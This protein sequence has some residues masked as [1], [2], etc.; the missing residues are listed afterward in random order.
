V[1]RRETNLGFLAVGRSR[2]AGWSKYNSGKSWFNLKK[3]FRRREEGGKRVPDATSLGGE[4]HRRRFHNPRKP[5]GAE[6]GICADVA[7]WTGGRIKRAVLGQPGKKGIADWALSSS[8]EIG[9]FENC[10]V[11]EWCQAQQSGG[12]KGEKEGK[13]RKKWKR[14]L[15]WLSPKKI[16]A[17]HS[18]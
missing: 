1:G 7:G 11:L 3:Q 9:R 6:N 4:K 2:N 8:P 16:G 17:N 14:G 13:E 18:L 10:E 5:E 15:K 12:K